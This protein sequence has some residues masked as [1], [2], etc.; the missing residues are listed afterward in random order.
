MVAA[1]SKGAIKRRRAKP[2]SLNLYSAAYIA[3]EA[4]V[5]AEWAAAEKRY[6]LLR[7]AQATI[8]RLIALVDAIE[9]DPDFEEDFDDT[10]FDADTEPNESGFVH[11][12]FEADNAALCWPP[13]FNPNHPW[14]A[15]EPAP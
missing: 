11:S 8:E 12:R 6:R 2:Y 14:T 10:G 9:G 5:E 1:K 7:R 15:A 3:K 13:G 4:A